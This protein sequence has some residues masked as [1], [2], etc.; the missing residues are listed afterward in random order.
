MQCQDIIAQ[1]GFLKKR[2]QNW[3]VD[4]FPNLAEELWKRILQ[5]EK[6]N[7][8]SYWVRIIQ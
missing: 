1:P 4:E 6:L 5:N 2:Q 7:M 8:P 3:P